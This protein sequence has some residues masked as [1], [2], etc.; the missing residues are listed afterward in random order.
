MKKKMPLWE[1]Q[2]RR[3]RP[4]ALFWRYGH[5]SV[6]VALSLIGGR[7]LV[8]FYFIGYGAYTIVIAKRMCLHYRLGLR[9]AHRRKMTLMEQIDEE[10]DRKGDVFMGIFFIL[11]GAA[12]FFMALF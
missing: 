10:K 8:P 3:A 9:D 11:I 5:L 2:E 6:L 7:Q 4:L 12:M 1:R